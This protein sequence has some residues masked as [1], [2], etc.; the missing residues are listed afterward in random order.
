[1]PAVA[2]SDDLMTS[3]DEA[4]KKYPDRERS[5]PMCG[6]DEVDFGTNRSVTSGAGTSVLC[7]GCRYTETG[8]DADALYLKWTRSAMNS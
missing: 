6:G 5:C 2:Q 8:S 3:I 1:M 7:N 4:I